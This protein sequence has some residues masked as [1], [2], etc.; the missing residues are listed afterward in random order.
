MEN[1]FGL[2]DLLLVVLLAGVILIVLLAMFQYDRQ[3]QTMKSIERTVSRQ[4]SDTAEQT[5]TLSEIRDLL[6][7][8]GSITPTTG[9]SALVPTGI[10]STQ[11]V[12]SSGGALDPFI[13]QHEA[14]KSAD[15]ARGDWYVLN[16][17]TR[18]SKLTP[19]L[20]SDVY[21]S[22]I[23]NRIIETLAYRDPDTLAW[24]PLL[25]TDWKASDDGL[26]IH[27][28][29]RQGV[30]FSDGSPCTADDYVFA[31]QW[32]MNPDVDA[33]RQRGGYERLKSIDK[34]NDYEIVF[35]FKEPFFQSFELAASSSPLSK[36]FYSKFTPKQ[37][38]ETV[39]ALIGTGPYRLKDAE[40]WRPGSQLEL[41]RNERYWGEPG[42]FNR[43][44]YHEVEEDSASLTMFRNG[45]LDAFGALP[46]QYQAL[47]GDADLMKRVQN[48]KYYSRDGGYS[49]I[50]WNQSR[51]GK[52]TR[53]ADKRV[54]Q[55]MTM[56]IDRE[57][58]ARDLYRGFAKPA[59]GPFGVISPQNAPDI[60]PW[61][62]DPKRA[63]QLLADAGY[64]DRNEDG[65]LVDGK[66]EPFRFKLIY[67][68]KNPLGEQMVLQVKDSL[69]RVGIILEQD[70]TDWPI[71]LKKI[72]TRDFDAMTLGWSGGIETDIHQMFHSS[73][74]ADN[75]DNFMSYSNPELD[76]LIDQAR[77]TV[78]EAKRM[79]VWH[80]AHHILHED[81]PY[82]FMLYRQSLL[83]IDNRIKNVHLTRSGL[84]YL[85]DDVM[86]IPWYVPKALQ[87]H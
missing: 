80:N 62:Y 18:V 46:E 8:G 66:G 24:I 6:A 57:R 22:I 16:M 30:T 11:P 20:S 72:N 7:R 53:F 39:G 51:V 14:M 70:P 10:S 52:P 61:P 79:P 71:M 26:S 41:F 31:F 85:S 83:F 29:L 58:M 77:R 42:P 75:A 81:Q 28:T 17:G 69:A 44:F 21:A 64:R 48:F 73:Q 35:Q 1:R 27:F 12:F 43:I 87:K 37:F 9:P 25:A 74:I 13:H 82:T 15:Y 38:N 4:S 68:S 45:E 40:S 55:A 19:L 56:L 33:P 86:P 50:A 54:R 59:P 63:L 84:N 36:Q 65:L 47:I 76:K 49:Y 60:K 67:S 78:D 34:V 3:W 23:Q 5:R 2:K 32:I